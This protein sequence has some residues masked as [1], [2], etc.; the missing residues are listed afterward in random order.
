MKKPAGS[1]KEKHGRGD[2]HETLGLDRAF[3]LFSFTFFI[4][5]PR[6]KHPGAALIFRRR[7]E[8]IGGSG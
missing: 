6:E 7:F 1:R 8:E 4:S 5:S 3:L 2:D